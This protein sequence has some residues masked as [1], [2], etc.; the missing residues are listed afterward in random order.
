MKALVLGLLVASVS[1]AALGL[2]VTKVEPVSPGCFWIWIKNTHP[3]EYDT[4]KIIFD[5][6]VMNPSV[7]A[8]TVN[9]PAIKAVEVGANVTT[10]KLA[11]PLKPGAW[12]WVGVCNV[13]SE[14]TG[15]NLVKGNKV[16]PRPICR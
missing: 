8:L 7:K 13:P 16:Y 9:G 14:V 4:F 5:G 15:E 12:L 3:C 1:L 10:I 6:K 2:P 11:A